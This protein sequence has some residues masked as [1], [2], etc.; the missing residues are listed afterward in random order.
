MESTTLNK[1]QSII[2]MG[3]GAYVAANIRTVH[4]GPKSVTH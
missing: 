4:I 1:H 2:K 3:D